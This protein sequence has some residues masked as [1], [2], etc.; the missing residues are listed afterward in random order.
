MQILALIPAR[1]GSKSIKDK[2]IR[3]LAGK[4][5]IAYSI[6]HALRSQHVTRTIVSTDSEAYA[7][8]A[9]QFGAE[10]PFLRPAELAQDFSTDLDVFTHALAWLAE[11]EGYRPDICVH[12]R[13][14]Y[15]FRRPENID[16]MVDLLL[17]H[18]DA[19]AVRSVAPAPE[20]PFKMWFVKDDGYLRPVV[21][22]DIP[23]AYNM[24]RQALP[25]AYLQNAC[26]D[27]VRTS[28]LLEQRSMTGKRILG[29]IMDHNYD[30]D[31]E[32]QFARVEE[33]IT[34]TVQR[35]ALS[36]RLKTFCFD[37][38]GV[39]AG[40]EPNNQY[41]Q[42]PPRRAMIEKIN[43]LYDLGHTII[44]FTAR[45]TMTGIDWSGVT[46][47]QMDAWGVKYHQL[48][49]GKPAADY[50]IDDKFLSFAQLD[51]VIAE[52]QNSGATDS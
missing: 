32:A 29:Y 20:T 37:I 31:Y 22:S 11:H 9:R 30:I 14:T 5:L 17:H 24:P 27:V 26:I 21:A 8:I 3:L 39:I 36:G 6:E 7:K 46:R 12:L 35:G 15:P 41:D 25:P 42:S 48:L 38:D 19:D 40:L 34:Q 4:P 50:Y 10:T 13:P 2:N 43:T 51:D 47:R 16:Q 49:F 52:L 33:A 44:L 18:P 45:G 23:D 1:S 28:T